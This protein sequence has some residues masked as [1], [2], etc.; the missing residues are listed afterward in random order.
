MWLRSVSFPAVCMF[1]CLARPARPFFVRRSQ[2]TPSGFEGKLS[3]LV[4]PSA[5]AAGGLTFF[6]PDEQRLESGLYSR[7]YLENQMA[8][9]LGGRIAEEL[10]F[11]EDEITTGASNDFQQVAPPCDWSV[12]PTEPLDC[13]C[14]F[15]Q[16]RAAARPGKYPI[17]TEGGWH[18]PAWI[19]V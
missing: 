17:P 3:I 6:A 5:G 18:D 19:A 14:R 12:L 10:I 11:G 7:S 15:T 13:L 1:S 9:A 16:R 2:N 4:N 8:V